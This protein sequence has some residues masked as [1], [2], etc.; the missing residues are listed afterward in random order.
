MSVLPP[1]RRHFFDGGPCRL[2][3]HSRAGRTAQPQSQSQSGVQR[4]PCKLE[5]PPTHPLALADT[6]TDDDDSPPPG[7]TLQSVTPE[8]RWRPDTAGSSPQSPKG[9]SHCT[10]AVGHATVRVWSVTSEAALQPVVGAFV[11]KKWGGRLGEL[12]DT[13]HL[14]PVPTRPHHTQLSPSRA[15]SLGLSLPVPAFA[16]Q[17][18]ELEQ[19]WRL[20]CS[21][22]SC[23][24]LCS[25][26]QVS[27]LS[28]SACCSLRRLTFV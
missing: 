26:A 17:S 3:C 6:R 28:G 24:W 13:A 11:H 2:P 5:A 1:V 14:S 12:D 8:S 22:S 4:A 10:A 15:H 27:E 21:S 20:P 19:P 9:Q 18:R 23:C 16:V 25:Q 7:F